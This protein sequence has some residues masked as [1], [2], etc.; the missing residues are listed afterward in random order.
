MKHATLL[1][2]DDD[3]QVLDAM[4]GWLRDLGYDLDT[5]SSL[6]GAIEAIDRKA[7]DLV[8][9]DIHLHVMVLAHK[10]P[11]EFLHQPVCQP[12]G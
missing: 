6:R 11:S 10:Q 3:H 8:L 9:A 2:V 4:A 5:E 7:Y 1:L 12:R